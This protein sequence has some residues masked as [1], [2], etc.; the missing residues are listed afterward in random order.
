[1]TLILELPR[2]IEE[3]I[4]RRAMLESLSPS[5]VAIELLA[6]AT[7]IAPQSPKYLQSRGLLAGYKNGPSSANI[8]RDRR[9]EVMRELGEIE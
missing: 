9:E 4:E 1:M 3:E 8:T 2:E 5:Q 7:R 6:H